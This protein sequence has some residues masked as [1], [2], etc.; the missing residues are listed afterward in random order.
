MKKV[1]LLVIPLILTLSVILKG[2]VWRDTVI[3]P[4]SQVIISPKILG[5][6]YVHKI[7]PRDNLYYVEIN[8]VFYGVTEIYKLADDNSTLVKI[9]PVEDTLVTVV[10]FPIANSLLNEG[11]KCLLGSWNEKNIETVFL[12]D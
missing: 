10:E 9:E 4:Y 3:D 11:I 5:T 1:N 12:N 8:T 6:G 2:C 7:S